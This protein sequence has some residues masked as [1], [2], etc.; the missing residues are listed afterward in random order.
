MSRPLLLSLSLCLFAVGCGAPAARYVVDDVS[1][2]A[3][4][5]QQ[6][7]PVY[8]AEQ[9]L[10]VA[11]ADQQKVNA[12]LDTAKKEINSVDAEYKQY[13]LEVDKAK[14]ESD[15][16]NVSK[17]PGRIQSATVGTRVADLGARM[18]RS[19]LDAAEGKKKWLDA[20]ADLADSKVRLQLARREMEKAKIAAANNIK[21]TKDF[22]V[23][24]F[25]DEYA[26]RERY[27]DEAQ[28]KADERK[29][30]VGRLSAA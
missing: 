8:V 16:A 5:M 20:L 12:D 21:P 6:K 3:V 15:L 19:R 26:K 24:D 30:D 22:N 14:I 18:A 27:V 10:S 9:D 29:A 11:R 17:D 28:R 23:G 25:L 13:R 1:I 7:Q 4:P 2:A